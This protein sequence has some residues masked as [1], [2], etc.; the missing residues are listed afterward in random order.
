MRET[1]LLFAIFGIVDC[2]TKP[3]DC[4]HNGNLGEPVSDTKR[5]CTKSDDCKDNSPHAH[6]GAA[7][8]F[9]NL[10]FLLCMDCLGL[11]TVHILTKIKLTRLTL[12]G[13]SLKKSKT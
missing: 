3:E 9:C 13:E 10:E 6:P 1:V 4:E 2:C 5:F 8:K 12:I 11:F 7:K